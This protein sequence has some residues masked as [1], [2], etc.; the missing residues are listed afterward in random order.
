MRK[1]KHRRHREARRLK[2]TESAPA[3]V[4][5]CIECNRRPHAE[6]CMAEF[7]DDDAENDAEYD[8]A[9]NDDN[10]VADP[11]IEEG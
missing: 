5:L 10:D 7:F 9:D 2:M 1:G 4:E 11:E 8:D 3:T 6:W